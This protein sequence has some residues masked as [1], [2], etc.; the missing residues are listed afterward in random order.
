MCS[1]RNVGCHLQDC[2]WTRDGA[3]QG[4]IKNTKLSYHLI[5]FSL[6]QYLLDCYKPLTFFQSAA[7]VGSEIYWLFFNAS[8]ERWEFGVIYS[9]LLTSRQH[10]MWGAQGNGSFHLGDY[11]LLRLLLLINIPKLPS[12]KFAIPQA[13]YETAHV[14]IHI[15]N[16][17]LYLLFFWVRKHHFNYN[18]H[19]K[20]FSEINLFSHVY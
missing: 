1:T 2:Y 14:F 18:P 15:L 10:L 16:S 20:C 11:W 17:F 9:I 8:V 6:L 5:A 13:M 4:P 3:G 7:K 19:Y 12:K